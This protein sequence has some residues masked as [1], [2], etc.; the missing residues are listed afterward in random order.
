MTGPQGMGPLGSKLTYVDPSGG[1]FVGDDG[2]RKFHHFTSNGTFIKGSVTSVDLLAVG[3]GGAAGDGISG[4][5]YDA[6][7]AG[8]TVRELQDVPISSDEVITVGL[9]GLYLN[10]GNDIPGGNGGHTVIGSLL[11]A[12]GGHGGGVDGAREGGDNADFTGSIRYGGPNNN[13]GAGAGADGNGQVN[14]FNSTGGAGKIT[15]MTGD[16]RG[17]GG[18]GGGNQGSANVGGAGGGGGYNTGGQDQYGGGGGAQSP[19]GGGDGLAIVAYVA[20]G[21]PSLAAGPPVYISSDLSNTGGMIDKPAG[22]Q[23]GDLL[24]IHGVGSNMPPAPTGGNFRILFSKN[25]NNNM[26][27]YRIINDGDPNS[28]TAATEGVS[29]YSAIHTHLFRGVNARHILDGIPVNGGQANSGMTTL[30]PNTMVLFLT[31]VLSFSGGSLAGIDNGFTAAGY[32]TN[33][34]SFGMAYKLKATAGAVGATSA[35]NTHGGSVSLM[36]GLRSN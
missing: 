36:I 3:A 22:A 23:P 1:S 18:A 25:Y 32:T 17:G 5:Y 7:G 6:G 10:A 21:A 29:G 11:T 8:G 19:A 35:P 12:T 30:L 20:N 24:I 13:S 14:A 4:L 33:N 28:W 26:I 16:R 15:L 9:G 34:P 31:S 27:W 2:Y